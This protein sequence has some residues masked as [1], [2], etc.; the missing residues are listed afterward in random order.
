MTS[1]EML[2]TTCPAGFWFV[3]TAGI[4]KKPNWKIVPA[5]ERPKKGD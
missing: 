3:N 4:G 5:P 1:K 2:K